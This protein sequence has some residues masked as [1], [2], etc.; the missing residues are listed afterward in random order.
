MIDRPVAQ[1]IR[2]R[3]F[4]EVVEAFQTAGAA[5]APIYDIGQ[6]LQ[7]PHVLARES[8]TTIQDADLGPLKMQN[9][10]FRLSE[11]PGAIRHGGRRL[12]QDNTDVLGELCGVPDDE[13]ES[14]RE[15]GII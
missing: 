4:A 5:L 11:T 8:V 13:L 9:L 7:D 2:E 3:P 12:G 6:L 10:F 15:K 14:L 1:W